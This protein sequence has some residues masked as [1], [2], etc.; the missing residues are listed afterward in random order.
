MIDLRGKSGLLIDDIPEMRSALRIQLA[1]AGLEKCDMARTIKEAIERISTNRYDLIVSD[2]N[3]GQGADGQQL[4]ELVRRKQVLPMTTAFMMITGETGYEQ[5][6]TAAEYSPDDYLIKPFTAETLRSRLERVLERKAA[7][8]PLFQQLGAKGDKNLALEA[9]ATLITTQPR[10]LTDILRIRGQL[11]MDLGQTEQALALYDMV[12]SQRATPWAEVGKASALAAQGNSD[13]AQ[14]QLQHA[15]ETYPNYL[16]AY[17]TLAQLVEKTDK[18]AAQAI[19]EQALKVAPSTQRQRRLGGLAME[20]KDFARAEIAFK[21]AVEKDRTGFFKEHGDY[22]GLAKSCSEQGKFAEAMTAIK[23]MGQHFANSPELSARQAAVESQVLA[24]AGKTTEAKAALER[25]LAVH[26]QSPL[27]PEAALEIAS[28]CFANGDSARAK[29]IIQAVAED[30]QE[31]GGILAAAHAVFHAA[32]LGD[33]GTAF[34]ETTRKNMIR[35]N[36]EAV[37]LARSGELEQAITMLQAAADRLTNNAQVAIN[38]ALAILMDIQ[39]NG[40]KRDRLNKA[41][42]YLLQ[43]HRANPT[44]ARL[45]EVAKL[46]RTLAP[47]DAAPLQIG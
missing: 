33:E 17:D 42:A 38:A 40:M 41:H 4:L 35:L 1:D 43:A 21:R 7:L 14:G 10:Y 44:H 3:L 22:A 16:A 9:C 30:H 19:V 11:L 27:D 13:K 31:N 6:S 18:V 23:G 45:P 37:G 32:G 28:A 20:N 46:Y 26:G 36:N 8:K 25:A 24:K 5:V 34:L 2:Y 15:L 47:A 12:L 29:N 39:R